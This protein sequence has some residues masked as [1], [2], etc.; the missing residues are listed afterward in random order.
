MEKKQL[1]YDHQTRRVLQVVER[2]LGIQSSEEK[3]LEEDGRGRAMSSSHYSIN[4]KGKL[5]PKVTYMII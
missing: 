2:A 1:S 5:M 3:I 4:T